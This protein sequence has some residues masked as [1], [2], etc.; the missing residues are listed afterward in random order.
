MNLLQTIRRRFRALAR[1]G[2]LDVEMDEEMRAHIE[3]RTQ[4]N[5]ET[6]MNP[7]EAR[8]AALRQFGWTESIKET[9]REQRGIGWLENLGQDLR[10]GARQLRKNPG[11]TAVAVLTLALGIGANTAM[12]SLVN[13]VLLKPLP[14]RD[15]DR[16]V[17]LSENQREQ[18]QDYVN[19]TAPGFTDWRRQ[20]TV[21][22]DLAAYQ[23]GGFDLTG[24]GD[25]ARLSGIRASASLFPLLRVQPELG[26]GFTQAEDTFEGDRVAVI[27]HRLWRERFGSATNVLGK[28]ITL[29]GNSYTIVG[30][31]SDGFWFA[32]LDADIWL[33]MAF[34]PWEMEN[35]GGHNYQAIGRLKPG[36][37]LDAARAEMKAITERLSQQFELSRGWGATMRPLQEQLVRGSERPLYV[38]FG[39]VG[40]VLLIACANVANLLLARALGRSRE[41]AIRGSLGAGRLR[42]VRQLVLESLILAGLGATAGWLLACGSL[43]ALLQLGAVGL[44]RLENIHLDMAVAGFSILVTVV[45]GI[46]FGLAPA[47]FA[48]RVSLGEVLKDAARGTT[49]KRGG[50]IRGSFVAIQLALALVLLV[51]AT[52]MLRSF[53]RI[54]ALNPGYVPEHILT[55][56]LFMPDSRFPGNSFS[57]R[58]PFRKAFLAQ[59]V[60]RAAALPGVESAAVVMGMPLT[61]VGAS[62][63]VFVLGRPEPKPSEPQVS[64]YS[65]VSPNY[66]Q[67]MG[68]PLLRGRH[69][70]N[71]DTVAAPFVA[72][73]NES[74]ARTF[75]PTG[76][77]IGQRLRVMDGY[78]DQP[79]EIVG[80]IRDTRQRSITAQPAPEMYFPILQRCWFV[81]QIVLKTK[82]DPAAQI[83]ALTK[84]V[85]GLD[86]RQPLYAVRTLSSLMADSVAQQRLQMLLLST[87]AGVALLLALVGVY[88]VMACVAAQRRHEI[89][90]RMSLGAQ[91]HQVQGLILKQVIR[92]S[93]TGIMA[94]LLAAYGLTRFLRNLLFEVSSSDPLTF[95]AVPCV[96]ALAAL[97]GGW[98]PARRAAKVDPMEALRAE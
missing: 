21:F 6:G 1:K 63:Q 50:R 52:L 60:E 54:H 87:F 14:Y 28:K 12:F 92:L 70:D 90:V 49:A 26:R 4:K 62:M 97:A 98:L 34:E 15:S 44:P 42:I 41:F 96:L 19:L 73:V 35:R 84:A 25:P 24:T 82:G 71:H 95:I 91:R 61:P 53:A 76:E 45:T 59:V 5:V 9:C 78:R 38:L 48:S 67:T 56:S 88:G 69:F 29:D 72:I 51:G 74:F 85:A 81:G 8:F 13:G 31:M 32:G 65:Q 75:F 10:F 80:I 64:G 39:A 83:P 2:K 68:I 55:G 30:I 86:S 23:P 37:T 18:G 89:G 36:V 22:E 46:A 77:V 66:F 40:F 58:E 27:A 16:L 3:M 94:G 57:E 7:E 93:G 20:S 47:W 33:P 79:T 43:A 17:S 11:F